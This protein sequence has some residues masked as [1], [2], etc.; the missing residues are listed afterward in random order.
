VRW[1][2]HR[3]WVVEADLK[4]GARH[5]YS[6]RFYYLDEDSWNFALYDSFDQAGK[7]YRSSIWM[8]YV[9]GDRH[10][11]PGRPGVLRPPARCLFAVGLGRAGP[12]GLA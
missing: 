9:A 8:L 3:V 2:L 11:A 6:E 10:S 4:P 5:I 7:L 1:E 12:D